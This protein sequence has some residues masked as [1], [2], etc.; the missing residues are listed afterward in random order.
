MCVIIT[1]MIHL[2]QKF[3]QTYKQQYSGSI[4][5][6]IIT[7]PAT[8]PPLNRHV[9]WYMTTASAICKALHSAGFTIKT[10]KWA[11]WSS[12]HRERETA[13]EGGNTTWHKSDCLARAQ[14]RRKLN[15]LLSLSHIISE[16]DSSRFIHL[17]RR[18][19]QNNLQSCRLERFFSLLLSVHR[20][21][22]PMSQFPAH[23][24]FILVGS[25]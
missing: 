2:Y 13:P 12:N 10:S 7:Y 17:Q 8:Y 1:L 3:K 21:L 24:F 14:H 16:N 6:W 19:A 4:I 23:V 25:T 9:R 20:W 22:L 18:S 15:F 11:H 5:L